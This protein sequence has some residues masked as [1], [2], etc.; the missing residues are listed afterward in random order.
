MN[1]EEAVQWIHAREKFKIKPGL[2]RM[3]WMMDRL[4]H[5]EEQITAV[6]VAGTNGKGSTVSFLRNILEGQGLSVGTFTSPYIETFNERI[7]VNGRPI[8]DE[9]LAEVVDRIRP[10]SEE[11]KHTSL[12][13]PTE[14][15]VITAAA[16]L[17]FSRMDLD[18]VLMETGLGGTY[19][20]TNI[21]RPVLSVIT[22]IGHDHMNILGSTIGEIAGE[23]AGIIKQGIP[24]VT[25]AAQQEAAAVLAEKAAECHSSVF[26]YGKD[27]HADHLTSGAGRETFRFISESFVSPAWKSSMLGPHQVTNASLAI[28]AAEVLRHRGAPLE[29][30][31]YGAAI[32]KTSWPGRFETI[33]H[34][35]LTIV[36][37]AHNEE[38]TGA[39]VETVKRHYS[40]RRIILVYAALEDK[41]V[42]KML[43][44]LKEVADV[45]FV[46]TFDFPRALSAEDL[47]ELSP[48]PHT[49]AVPDYKTAVRE[50][51]A[52]AGDDDVVLI[53]GSLYFISAIRTFLK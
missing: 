22:N 48:V 33:R 5:P 36:D 16:L 19:D 42:E 43:H 4:N 17:H 30:Q 52:Q 20:S 27:F 41:P 32:E 10:L 46:T 38:G 14:F 37:G 53:S 21:I 31:R 13:E 47:E 29:R 9:E 12:G 6:H 7:S 11:L 40:D 26:W 25:G 49:E 45:L 51:S 34:K 2:K 44:K 15:E 50:A 18:F 8:A 35:P 23:K 39:L 3:E 1:Y 28:Q 24:L